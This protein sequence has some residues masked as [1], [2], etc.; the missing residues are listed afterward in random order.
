MRRVRGAQAGEFCEVSNASKSDPAEWLAMVER[1]I[2]GSSYLVRRVLKMW[3]ARLLS[4]LKGAGCRSLFW[5]P[6][7]PE[8]VGRV[9]SSGLLRHLGWS[10]GDLPVPRH[11]G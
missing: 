10:A 7:R 11:G 5:L 9:V 2:Q 4:W 6:P 3:Q 1:P 8:F